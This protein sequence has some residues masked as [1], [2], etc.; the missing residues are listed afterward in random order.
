MDKGQLRRMRELQLVLHKR[1]SS[2]NP[3]G[4]DEYIESR[5]KNAMAEARE[6][7]TNIEV[8]LHKHVIGTLK[9]SF[10]EDDSGWWY[11]GVPTGIR[12]RI[13]SEINDEG[14]DSP[15]ESRFNLIDYRTL[16]TKHWKLFEDTLFQGKAHDSK[17][18]RTSWLLQVNEIR[19]LAAHPTK[20]TATTENVQYLR[21]QWNWLHAQLSSMRILLSRI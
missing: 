7:L 21:E 15:K 6:L 13:L 16:A 17:D 11:Q 1:F 18:N 20:G 14:R 2:F 19:K 10:G 9:A 12:A 5:D 4:L 3:E 8:A